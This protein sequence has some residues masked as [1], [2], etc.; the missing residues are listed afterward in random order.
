M[1]G[2]GINLGEV[3][4][5]R[6]QNP[7]FGALRFKT[8]LDEQTCGCREFVVGYAEVQ[9]GRT[10]PLHRRNQTEF[11]LITQGRAWARLGRCRVEVEPMVGTYFQALAPHSYEVIGPE[12]LG[13]WYILATEKAGQDLTP[14]LVG[15][16]EANRLFWP[17]LNE[18]RWAVAEDFE[19][20]RLWE[21][22][23]GR[24][25]LHWISMFDAERGGHT[26]MMPG[27]GFIP[28]GGRYSKHYHAQPEIFVCL[29]GRGVLYRGK[30]TVRMYPGTALYVP[31]NTVHGGQSFSTSTM[32]MI[33][34]YGTESA[35]TYWS[36][37]PVED[38]K[39]GA[40]PE[41]F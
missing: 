40:V 13:Y 11:N 25:G 16:D 26:E 29:E 41:E 27:T 12:P 39:L 2:N 19:P 9:P 7:A 24:R 37:T 18:T 1:Q 38:I 21:P 31:C 23:K 3:D 15:E 30:E 35:S 4:W 14:S 17:N 5:Q 34:V 20:W 8:L 36:W 22:T 10:L 28:P 32:K 6:S 33:W